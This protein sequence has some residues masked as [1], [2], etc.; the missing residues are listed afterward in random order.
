MLRDRR[1]VRLLGFLLA[2]FLLTSLA[3]R[4]GMCV[5]CTPDAIKNY[6]LNLWDRCAG[7]RVEAE[8]ENKDTSSLKQ[9]AVYQRK[10]D[11][12]N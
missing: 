7:M 8:M 3:G 9:P 6:I 4:K 12:Y 10:Y 11:T 5:L 1:Q 2:A